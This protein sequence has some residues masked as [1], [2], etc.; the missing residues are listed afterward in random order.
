VDPFGTPYQY[1]TGADAINNG[2]NFFDLW[3]TAGAPAN[4]NAWIKN[5]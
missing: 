1:K 2:S 5:W 3:S 4:S